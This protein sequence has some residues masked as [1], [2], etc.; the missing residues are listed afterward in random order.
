MSE[1]P[2]EG[3]P[4]STPP[5]VRLAVNAGV[6]SGR[7]LARRLRRPGRTFPWV[8]PPWPDSVARP[9]LP[10]T[11]GVDYDTAWA[12]RYPSRLARLVLTE[13][14]T[15]PVMRAVANPTVEGLDRIAHLRGPVIFAANHASHLDTPLLLSVLPEPWRHR[16]V[17]AAGA[18]Y[19]FDSRIKAA[20][21]SLAIN[22]IPIERTRVNRASAN[23]AAALVE[24]GWSLLIFPEGGRSPDGWAQPHRAGAA[25]LAV[26]T[27]TPVVPIYVEGTGAIL[28]RHVKR[29]RPGST[30]VA[31]GRPLASDDG[32][33]ARELADRLQRAVTTLADEGATD[34]WTATKRAAGRTSPALTGPDVAST[35]RRSWALG[36][37]AKSRGGDSHQRWPAG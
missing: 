16:T 24:A 29:L 37:K 28:A 32:S 23:Q 11:L 21:F 36:S 22:A 14:I 27:A 26:R 31:F 15:T 5:A 9:P 4:G 25:W 7:T 20:T 33:D 13:A 1:L 3:L 18:D 34:W 2:G 17:V 8:S 19:F 10:R 35:W 30:R 6:N 12:R